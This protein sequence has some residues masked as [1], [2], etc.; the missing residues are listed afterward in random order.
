MPLV[1]ALLADERFVGSGAGVAA[2]AD[3]GH[4]SSWA[5]WL[6]CRAP[7][8]R[9]WQTADGRGVDQITRLI[10]GIKPVFALGQAGNLASAGEQEKYYRAEVFLQDGSQDYDIVGYTKEQIIID[11]LSQYERHMQFL[12][13]ER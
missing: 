13:L 7:Q 12:H 6:G 5:V 3:V 11:I 2:G 4:W 10:E 8:W 1:A 9:H